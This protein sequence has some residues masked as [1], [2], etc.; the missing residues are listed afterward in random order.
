MQR[1]GQRIALIR[2]HVPPHRDSVLGEVL[3]RPML[4]ERLPLQLPIN[5][6]ALCHPIVGAHYV[7]PAAQLKGLLRFEVLH[8]P[9]AVICTL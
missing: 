3:D 7:V 5:I 2:V 4:L 6:D 8:L 1:T 9:I